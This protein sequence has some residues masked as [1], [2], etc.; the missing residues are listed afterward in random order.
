MDRDRPG[1]VSV[2]GSAHSPD[3]I[4]DLAFGER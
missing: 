3:P 1:T 4:V 2:A